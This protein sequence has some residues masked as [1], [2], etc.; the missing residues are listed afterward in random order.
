MPEEHR[1]ELKEMLDKLLDWSDG[2]ETLDGEQLEI[3][4]EAFREILGDEA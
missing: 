3:A 2:G 4:I 1:D